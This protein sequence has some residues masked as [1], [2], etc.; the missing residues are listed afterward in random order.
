MIQFI[1]RKYQRSIN[2]YYS[3][4]KKKVEGKNPDFIILGTQKGGT[5]S[6]YNYLSNHSKICVG[7]RREIHFF[8]RNYEKGIY[9]YKNNFN[10]EN[11]TY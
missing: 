6:L 8:D 3:K 1:V 10:N 7:S 5:T 11:K 2:L 4:I 9:W